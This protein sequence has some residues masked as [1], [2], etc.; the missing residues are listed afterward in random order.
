[1]VVWTKEVAMGSS[2][3]GSVE[4][5]L[6]SIHEDA[7]STLAPLSGLRI[8]CCHELWCRSQTWLRSWVAVAVIWA[9]GYS[10]NLTPNLG[11]SICHGCGTKNQKKKKKKEEAMNI[12]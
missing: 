3:H 7:G 4:M 6:T 12:T 11:T 8:W 9:G 1:M 10:S 5:N 2:H